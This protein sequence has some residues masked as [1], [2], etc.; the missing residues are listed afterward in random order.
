MRYQHKKTG[1]SFDLFITIPSI[2]KLM[3]VESMADGKFVCGKDI[4]TKTLYPICYA[5]DNHN[6][7]VEM[8][9]RIIKDDYI[10]T[11][12]PD[13]KALTLSQIQQKE[14]DKALALKT[15]KDI[16]DV[17]TFDELDNDKDLSIPEIAN[18]LADDTLASMSNDEKDDFLSIFKDV[19]I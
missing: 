16:A 12:E 7:N 6:E 8:I 11:P 1:K 14:L 19:N 5:Y 17:F 2:K 15:E 18:Q 13:D 3:G 4:T 10:I 9:K